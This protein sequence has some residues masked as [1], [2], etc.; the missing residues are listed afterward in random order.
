MSAF[1]CLMWV[2]ALFGLSILIIL[3]TELCFLAFV[4]IF[5]TV[6]QW[7]LDLHFRKLNMR[8]MRDE[9]G[10]DWYVG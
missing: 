9:K 4:F 10:I 3:F 8:R 6:D 1:I 7:L 5:G 2:A